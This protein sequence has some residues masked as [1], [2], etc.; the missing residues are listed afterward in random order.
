MESASAVLTSDEVLS[1]PLP[2]PLRLCGLGNAAWEDDGSLQ[3]N[4]A[5]HQPVRLDGYGR[6]IV[7]G[8]LKSVFHQERQVARPNPIDKFYIDQGATVCAA[9]G[10]QW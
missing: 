2:R 9:R 1:P 7:V 6:R 3:W 4:L 5:A 10:V 8:D